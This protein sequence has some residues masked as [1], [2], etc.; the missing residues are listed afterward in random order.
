MTPQY[1]KV[2]SNYR[3]LEIIKIMSEGVL[4]LNTPHIYIEKPSKVLVFHLE[5]VVPLRKNWVSLSNLTNETK[6]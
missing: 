3:L 2:A 5:Q 6:Y 4:G 1:D